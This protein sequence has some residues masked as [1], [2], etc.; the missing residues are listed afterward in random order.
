MPKRPKPQIP[1]APKPMTEEERLK[2]IANVCMTLRKRADYFLNSEP[3]NL[4]IDDFDKVA[5][6]LE[7]LARDVDSLLDQPENE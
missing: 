1:E 4:S 3:E 2:I 5:E 6:E 7:I